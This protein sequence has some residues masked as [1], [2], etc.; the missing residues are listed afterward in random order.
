MIDVLRF[1]ELILIVFIKYYFCLNQIIGIL[2]V[3]IV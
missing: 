3:A 2:I 1:S